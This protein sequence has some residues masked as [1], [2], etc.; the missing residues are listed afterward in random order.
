MK[1]IFLSL[2][3]SA[4]FLP[5]GAQVTDSALVDSVKKHLPNGWTAY[6]SGNK[7]VITK[8][9]SVWFYNAINAPVE[10]SPSDK[11]PFAA[12]KGVYRIEVR[13]EKK[14]SDKAVKSALKSN[15]DKMNAVYKK[16]NMDSIPNKMGDYAPRNDDEM[17]RVEAYNKECAELQKTLIEIPNAASAKYS[18]FIQSGRAFPGQEV[19]PFSASSEIAEVETAINQLLRDFR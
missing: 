17:I 15:T 1:N 8:T 19:W 2:L 10:M 13:Y 12:M 16:Y 9:D 7:I 11:P 14:W 3:A 18:Y 6:A 5:L 4:L